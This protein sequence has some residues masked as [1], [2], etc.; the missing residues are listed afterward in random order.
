LGVGLMVMRPIGRHGGEQE[1]RWMSCAVA[2][3]FGILRRPEAK[4]V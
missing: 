3:G 2:E 4:D 1:A